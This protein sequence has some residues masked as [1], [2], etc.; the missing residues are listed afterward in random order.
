MKTAISTNN[1]KMFDM[2]RN[3]YMTIFTKINIEVSKIT[4]R[5]V[6]EKLMREGKFTFVG[7]RAT[8]FLWKSCERYRRWHTSTL[9]TVNSIPIH[10]VIQDECALKYTYFITYREWLT[11]NRSM[12][13]AYRMAVQREEALYGDKEDRELRHRLATQPLKAR[14]LFQEHY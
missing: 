11:C 5:K 9:F 10:F 14:R 1:E 6:I 2:Y 4:F 8:E 3:E 13:K 12:V 7:F